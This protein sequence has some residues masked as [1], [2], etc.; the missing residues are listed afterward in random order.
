[1]RRHEH[2]KLIDTPEHGAINLECHQF[3]EYFLSDPHLV[4]SSTEND[5][6]RLPISALI[7]FN[8]TRNQAIETIHI[9][10]PPSTLWMQSSLI[11]ACIAVSM[12]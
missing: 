7:S 4:A 2:R 3:S 9:E 5:M 10:S 11:L 1:M 8:H 12:M 6:S